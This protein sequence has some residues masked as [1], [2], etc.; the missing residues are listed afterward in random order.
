M[1]NNMYSFFIFLIFISN[2]TYIY[3][4]KI[5]K[6]VSQ[7]ICI[8]SSKIVLNIIGEYSYNLIECNIHI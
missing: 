7:N 1:K 6:N 4:D 5:S 8:Y 3:N 2:P